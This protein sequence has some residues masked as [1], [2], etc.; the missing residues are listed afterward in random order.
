MSKGQDLR[1]YKRLPVNMKS[2]VYR[3]NDLNRPLASQVVSIS[4][5]G[6]LVKSD[7]PALTAGD[8]IVVE[9]QHGPG[10]LLKGRVTRVE[11]VEIHLDES[12]SEEPQ[13]QWAEGDS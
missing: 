13:M 9:I 1:R 2:V 6:A 10:Y 3:V 11:N 12:D 5:G 7:Q 4:Q 8:E